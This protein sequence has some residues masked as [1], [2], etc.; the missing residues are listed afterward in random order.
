MHSPNKGILQFSHSAHGHRSVR[1]ALARKHRT[2]KTF[3][4]PPDHYCADSSIRDHKLG[5]LQGCAKMSPPVWSCDLMYYK[6][7][8]H[9]LLLVHCFRQKVKILP[10][11]GM[12]VFAKKRSRYREK[13]LKIIY[14]Y[15]I[16]GKV[17]SKS[18]VEKA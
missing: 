18:A 10:R 6:T 1:A 7:F 3:K 14:F 16:R 13:L 11:F 9:R 4:A 5:I 15:R 8:F 12:F 2:A 17:C